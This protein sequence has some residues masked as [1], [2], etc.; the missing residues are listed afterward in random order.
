MSMN[1]QEEWIRLSK[2][3]AEEFSLFLEQLG[4]FF[5]KTMNQGMAGHGGA[6]WPLVIR[7]WPN[8]KY[9]YRYPNVF[10][11]NLRRKN[12]L[13]VFAERK[14]DRLVLLK[15]LVDELMAGMIDIHLYHF[16]T[17]LLYPYATRNQDEDAE[18]AGKKRSDYMATLPGYELMDNDEFITE[19]W[20]DLIDRRYPEVGEEIVSVPRLNQV[21][22][23]FTTELFG[24]HTG[25]YYYD[26]DWVE[27]ISGYTLEVKKW[28]A[29]KDPMTA[30]PKKSG[31]IEGPIML[32]HQ[33]SGSLRHFVRDKPI[34]A[35]D[36]IEVKFG[37]GWIP[38]RY[39]WDFEQ[40]EF[41]R[42]HSSRND[43]FTISEGHMVRIKS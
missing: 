29:E 17:W 27:P 8:G 31:M 23:L 24:N 21:R 13:F 12:D 16:G 34:H 43:C 19:V 20:A 18:S 35:G 33:G 1:V 22:M 42:I 14:A 36:Y 30:A 6:V 41:I 4:T 2:T 5:E 39:E 3:K 26:A 15:F 37:D 10:F 9:V 11:Q 28:T 40:G 25:R 38:G 32:G 7:R